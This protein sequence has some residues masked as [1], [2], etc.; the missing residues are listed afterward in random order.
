M[1]NISPLLGQFRCFD[2]QKFLKYAVSNFPLGS[3]SGRIICLC[4]TPGLGLRLGVDFVFP[5]HNKNKKASARLMPCL[6]LHDPPK[7][8]FDRHTHF[9]GTFFWP[10]FRLF[11]QRLRSKPWTYKSQ[12]IKLRLICHISMTLEKLGCGLFVTFKW[13]WKN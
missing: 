13:H 9:F 6:T 7:I 4:L 3:N 12:K 2:F 1:G 11:V 5:C 10:T 8:F